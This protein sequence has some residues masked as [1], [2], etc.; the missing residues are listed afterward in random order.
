M[1]TAEVSLATTPF[2]DPKTSYMH[3]TSAIVY[4]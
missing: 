4:D 1:P 2:M 3:Q